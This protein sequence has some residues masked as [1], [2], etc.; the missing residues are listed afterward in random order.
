MKVEQMIMARCTLMGVAALFSF[1]RHVWKSGAHQTEPAGIAL[2]SEI[3]TIYAPKALIEFAKAHPE[4]TTNDELVRLIGKRSSTCALPSWA[5]TI[6]PMAALLRYRQRTG[7]AKG[8]S[9][10]TT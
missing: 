7:P 5:G 6:W 9:V 8:R 10:L 3:L 2:R 4:I 1:D